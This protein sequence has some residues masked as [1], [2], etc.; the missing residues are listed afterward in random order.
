MF[1][2]C[3]FV[4]GL[5]FSWTL[6]CVADFYV[7]PTKKKNYAPVEKT[8]QTTSYAA[9]DDGDLQKGVT[10]PSPRF[11]DNGDGTV[12]DN[13]TGL[14]WLK[15]ANSFGGKTW[16][17][18]LNA[19]N[20]LAD[21]GTNLTDGSVAGDWRLP[22]VKELQSLIHFGF[23]YP[24]LPDTAGTG[25]WSEGNPFTNV[26]SLFYWSST[27]YVGQ[28]PTPLAWAWTVATCTTS[29]RTPAP[30]YGRCAAAIDPSEINWF[31]GVNDLI[32]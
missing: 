10:W 29:L 30:V 8:G 32:I 16:A 18:A 23:C 3:L 2:I 20:T 6:V 11:T 31:H 19:C 21:D 5:I 27:T 4:F 1:W 12:T 15:N 24:A 28:R 26:P 14:I 13:L 17:D 7:I 9:G 25:Q 22:N